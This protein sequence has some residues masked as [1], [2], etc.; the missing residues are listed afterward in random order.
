[1]LISVGVDLQAGIEYF[2]K[3]NAEISSTVGRCAVLL[4]R[5]EVKQS[6]YS[7]GQALRISGV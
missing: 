1:L 7:P 3:Q 5:L 2:N 6:H 4:D